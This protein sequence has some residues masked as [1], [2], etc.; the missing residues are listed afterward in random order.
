MLI[1]LQ[2][3]KLQNKYPSSYSINYNLGLLYEYIGENKNALF[4]Y[5]KCLNI[6]MTKDIIKRIAT[7][8]KNSENKKKIQL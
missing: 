4:Y 6:K 7:I 5:K 1:L 8:K 2:L 3:V